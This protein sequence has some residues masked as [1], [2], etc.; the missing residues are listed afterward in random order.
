MDTWPY[1]ARR[2]TPFLLVYLV[3]ETAEVAALALLHGSEEPGSLRDVVCLA[4]G[5]LASFC[6]CVLPYVL[7][8]AALPWDFHGGRVDR[9]VTQGL[10][11]LFCIV[12]A[13]EELSEVLSGDTF[14]L[15]SETLFLRPNEAWHS[16]CGLPHVLPCLVPVLA[17]VAGTYILMRRRLMSTSPPPPTSSPPPPLPPPAPTG[18]RSPA[19]TAT[20]CG[21]K[22]EYCACPRASP[23]LGPALR[24]AEKIVLVRRISC[25]K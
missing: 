22:N 2:L 11:L 16:I 20:F 23:F 3:Y 21:R 8:L 15:F 6:F 19:I 24:K 5:T 4:E 25:Y 13:P 10:F 18:T 17:V 12:N 7:Y 9:G 14:S 1:Y